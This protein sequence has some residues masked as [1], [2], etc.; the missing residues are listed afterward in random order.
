[1]NNTYI[2]RY[3]TGTNKPKCKEK[4]KDNDEKMKLHSVTCI[5]YYIP[6]FVTAIGE[7]TK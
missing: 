6:F 4:R 3:F 7:I 5:P 1:M 2:Y